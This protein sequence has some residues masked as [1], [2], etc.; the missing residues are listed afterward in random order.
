MHKCESAVC[1]LRHPEQRVHGCIVGDAI[2]RACSGHCRVGG[3]TARQHVG[4]RLGPDR[5]QCKR[6]K[7]RALH[8]ANHGVQECVSCIR[9][10]LVQS[11][12]AWHASAR[13]PRRMACKAQGCGSHSTHGT[14]ISA[15]AGSSGPVGPRYLFT[16]I[17]C[18]CAL[19]R[20]GTLRCCA[21]LPV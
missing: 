13:W 4:G 9:T 2:P 16:G 8:G 17:P 11:C 3:D 7:G 6:A 12:I 15:G 18:T 21:V 5:T 10:A 19:G 1:Q 20:R 14:Q